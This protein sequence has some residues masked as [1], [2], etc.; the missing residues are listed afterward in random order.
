MRKVPLRLTTRVAM[1]D[2]C[3]AQVAMA[4]LNAITAQLASITL[5]T[6]RAEN[7]VVPAGFRIARGLPMVAR[8]A[9]KPKLANRGDAPTSTHAAQSA[10]VV[11]ATAQHRNVRSLA[12]RGW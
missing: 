3:K 9:Y 6:P 4:E 8:G 5:R 7:T 1:C 2:G 11:F 12:A 10:K